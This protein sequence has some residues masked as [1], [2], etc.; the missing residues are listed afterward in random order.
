VPEAD[1][2]SLA[3]RFAARL[4]TE[5]LPAGPERSARFAEAVTLT[6]PRTT[7]ELYWCGLATLVADPS[8]IATFDRVFAI[9][10]EGFP[11]RRP[12]T[13]TQPDSPVPPQRA[14]LSAV[15]DTADSGPSSSDSADSSDSP[16][17]EDDDAA[18]FPTLATAEERLAGRDFASL[19]SDELALLV[20]VMRRLR[21]ATPLRKSRRYEP[22]SR[23][24]RIDLRTTMRQAQR[25]GGYPVSLARHRLRTRPRRLVVLCDISGSMEPYARALLQLIYCAMAAGGPATE[26]FTFATR[27]TRLTRVLAKVRPEVALERAGRAAPDWSGGTRIGVALKAFLDLYG[28]RGVARG[29]VVLIISDGWETG[30]ATELGEQMRRLSRLAYRIVWANPRTASPHY[31]PLVAGMAAAWPY[32][33]SVVSAHSLRA[34]DPLMRA[35][36]IAKR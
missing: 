9:V 19:S 14:D 28:A 36:A 3:A 2:A 20:D 22:G 27:L 25:S 5:G 10:F 32:C 23:G 29:A 18:P 16:E 15:I 7:K 12:G 4:R 31:Q 11:D 26:V 34:L 35:L 21:L 6:D 24:R 17:N 30:D 1:L 13:G 33:D 8:E